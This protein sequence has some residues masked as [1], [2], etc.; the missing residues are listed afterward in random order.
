MTATKFD[1]HKQARE[2]YCQLIITAKFQ[3]HANE[4]TGAHME[5]TRHIIP[6]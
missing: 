4:N 5:R 6:G 2:L 3:R 1:S